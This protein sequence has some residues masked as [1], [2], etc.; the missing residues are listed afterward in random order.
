MPGFLSESGLIGLAAFPAIKFAGYSLAGHVLKRSYD[1][2]GVSSARFGAARTA[3]GAIV[4]V[5]YVFLTGTLEVSVAQFYL[6]LIPV[7]IAEWSLIIW[8]FFEYGSLERGKLR[9]FGYSTLGA[10]WSYILDLFVILPALVIPGW[11]WVC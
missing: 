6:G 4:G 5:S 2:P 9:L 11:F 8:I 10:G 1:E 3:L 7:R